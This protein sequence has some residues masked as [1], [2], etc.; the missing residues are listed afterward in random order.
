MT[1]TSQDSNISVQ[2]NT[3]GPQVAAPKQ[4]QITAAAPAVGRSSYAAATKQS[5]LSNASGSSKMATASEGSVPSQRV[6]G[7]AMPTINGTIPALDPSI[8]SNGNAPLQA[9]VLE[10]SRTPSF[11]VASGGRTGGLSAS[12]PTKDIPIQFGTA[13][14][15]GSPASGQSPGQ[16]NASPANLGVSGLA[17][18]RYISPQT[19]PS[20]IPQPVVSGGR[21]PSGLQNQVNSLNFRHS[22]G[23][24]PNEIDVSTQSVMVT[25]TFAT[26]IPRGIFN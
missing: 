15:G 26:V 22:G 16:V 8:V 12:Q 9:N 14:S 25:A 5:I 20:P 18:P 11:T 21:P 3:S 7:E 10:H 6:N 13:N 24:E 19:S 23:P 2:A 17:N 1:S 4:G